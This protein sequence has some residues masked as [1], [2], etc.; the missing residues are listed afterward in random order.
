MD[1][2]D[3]VNSGRSA[4]FGDIGQSRPTDVGYAKVSPT[5]PFS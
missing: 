4:N 1:R 2:S 5:L 3:A